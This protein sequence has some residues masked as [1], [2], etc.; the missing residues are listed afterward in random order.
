MVLLCG[1]EGKNVYKLL[2]YI[3]TLTLCCPEKCLF[4]GTFSNLAVF[5]KTDFRV[6]YNVSDVIFLFSQ[7]D[8]FENTMKFFLGNG[9]ESL[10]L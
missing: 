10:S 8:L 2:T 9:D 1:N 6:N 7:N 5:V 4:T 3:W